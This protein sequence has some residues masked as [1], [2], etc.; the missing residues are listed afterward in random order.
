VFRVTGCTGHIFK[1]GYRGRFDAK[2]MRVK[3]RRPPCGG[4]F[5]GRFAFSGTRFLRAGIDPNSIYLP[6]SR[7]RLGVASRFS[8]G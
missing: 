2:P 1:T 4:Y 7:G 5:L 8:A 6:V 3:L